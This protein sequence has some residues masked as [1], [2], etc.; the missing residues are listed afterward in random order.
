[1]GQRGPNC[2]QALLGG[3]EGSGQGQNQGAGPY[4]R[5]LPGEDGMGSVS[6]AGS[7]HGLR[8]SRDLIVAHRSHRLWRP[9][10]RVQTG[11]PCAHDE[12]RV[13]LLD[14]LTEP[15]DHLIRLVRQQAPS[16]QLSGQL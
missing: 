2:L 4:D 9:V 8:K 5:D 12:S 11:A 6:K 15:G 16:D 14:G 13:L 1:V 7:P 3:F 10:A